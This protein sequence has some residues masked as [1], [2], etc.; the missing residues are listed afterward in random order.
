MNQ[1][2]D[3][4]VV[5]STETT[6][7]T[8]SSSKGESSPHSWK[9]WARTGE[10]K[11]NERPSTNRRNWFLTLGLVLSIGALIAATG[12]LNSTRDW[13]AARS[14]YQIRWNEVR[15]EPAPPAYIR[16][17]TSG[18]LAGVRK[19]L[20]NRETI[21]SLTQSWSELARALPLGSP[22]VEEVT[23]IG[24]RSYPN[25]LKIELVYRQPV[26]L[27]NVPGNSGGKIVLDGKGVVLP[28]DEVDLK[29]AGTLIRIDGLS[30][31][32]EPRPGF[33]LVSSGNP[34]ESRLEAGLRLANFA[35]S[36]SESSEL[37]AGPSLLQA[38]NLRYGNHQI[39]AQTRDGLWVLWGD[40][41]DQ[42]PA[43]TLNAEQKWNF[44][45]DWLTSHAPTADRPGSYL[46][47]TPTGASL[48]SSKGAAGGRKAGPSESGG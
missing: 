34:D 46:I 15:L 21:S 39:F 29:Q 17:G 41:P 9:R 7:S 16:T 19:R 11:Q 27:L 38:V 1:G 25:Q 42:E 45:K 10:L 13:L 44:L 12:W 48:Q 35:R 14:E 23:S 32:L 2:R 18:I 37:P 28:L 5:L 30:G 33:S 31:P 3:P 40:A 47:F 26:V 8:G 22:W 20:G 6:A 43:G 36:H 4:S 24:V